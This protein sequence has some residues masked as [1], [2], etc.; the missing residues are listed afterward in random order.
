MLTDTTS[1][2]YINSNN[3]SIAYNNGYITVTSINTG[4]DQIVDL[5]SIANDLK[6]KTVNFEVEID[7]NG[8]TGLVLR[9]VNLSPTKSVSVVDG[10]N[11]L[12]NVAIPSDSTVYLRIVK[13]N[14]TSG[15]SYKF[16]NIKIYPI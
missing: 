8:M 2:Y 15:N 11:K 3:V 12:E 7:P 6:G 14:S 16:K 1:N 5:R 4:T 10:V 9:T 13:T